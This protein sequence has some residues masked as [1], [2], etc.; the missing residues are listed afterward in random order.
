MKKIIGFAVIV[1]FVAVACVTPPD[2]RNE[3][4]VDAVSDLCKQEY[5]DRQP[6]TTRWYN[7]KTQERNKKKKELEEYK[8]K[9]LELYRAIYNFK[10]IYSASVDA[11]GI[12]K[13]GEC[14]ALEK[15][16]VQILEACPEAG[17][18]IPAVKLQ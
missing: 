18:K 14:A 6:S 11:S 4:S 10:R 13:G 16:R 15:I 2:R 12:C 1:F 17:G 3:F 5:L 9:Q 8:K 7:L